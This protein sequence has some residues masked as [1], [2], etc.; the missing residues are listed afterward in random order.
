MYLLLIL[1][2]KI[3]LIVYCYYYCSFDSEH[4]TSKQYILQDVELLGRFTQT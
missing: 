4:I 3:P 2:L 1:S